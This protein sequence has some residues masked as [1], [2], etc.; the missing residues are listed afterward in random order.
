MKFCQKCGK[1]LT[2]EYKY[3]LECKKEN[4]RNYQRNRYKNIIETGNHLKR[5]GFGICIYCGKEFI[6]NHPDQLGH[7][8]CRSSKIHKTVDN[9]NKVKRNKTG[10]ATIGRQ[11]ILD[12][13][14]NIP[15]N[16]VIHH[17]DENPSNNN[18]SNLI[19]LNRSY[20][21]SLHRQLEKEWS[22]SLKNDDSN[23]ENCWNI[24][25]DQI[26]TTYLETKDVKVIKISDIGQSAVEPLN[27]NFIYKFVQEEDSETMH[28]APKNIIHG[29]DIVQ[30]QTDKSGL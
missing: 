19:L 4:K 7:G 16:M 5:Y 27:T 17:L 8:P 20:H 28:Q 6:K 13:G 12:L 30:T 26:T 3:Y 25:R 11:T 29:E 9:Y 18:L 22:S 2:T 1:E 24:L 14:I 15:K 23:L 10:N 21:A